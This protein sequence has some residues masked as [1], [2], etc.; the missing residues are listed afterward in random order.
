MGKWKKFTG[1]STGDKSRCACKDY[2]AYANA[3][4]ARDIGNGRARI[5]SVT[6]CEDEFDHDGD[7]WVTPVDTQKIPQCRCKYYRAN[8][9]VCQCV[10]LLGGIHHFSDIDKCETCGLTPENAVA[11]HHTPE[12]ARC[13][14]GAWSL[15]LL[16]MR[17]ASKGPIEGETH[18][19][20]RCTLKCESP[21]RRCY[22]RKWPLEIVSSGSI[23]GSIEGVIHGEHQCTSN[24]ERKCKCGACSLIK[25]V[26]S[27]RHNG[28]SHSWEQCG[29]SS[30]FEIATDRAFRHLA[31]LTPWLRDAGIELQREH[32]EVVQALGAVLKNPKTGR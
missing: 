32:L 19:E 25:S 1:D 11:V 8:T 18:G 16:A 5:H 21:E 20:Q 14:C 23:G 26:K 29:P 12:P 9:W 13:N 3:A 15:E 6:H 31:A 10:G 30:E 27:I 24:N 22:C 7:I 4:Y 2:V 17:V 28:V